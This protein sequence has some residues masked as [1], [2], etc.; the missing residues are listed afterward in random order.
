MQGYEYQPLVELVREQQQEQK[1]RNQATL[2][3]QDIREGGVLNTVWENVKTLGAKPVSQ[4]MAGAN[5]MNQNVGE[6]LSGTNKSLNTGGEDFEGV[7]LSN[8]VRQETADK[9]ARGMEKFTGKEDSLLER[10]AV[11]AYQTVMGLGDAIPALL[12]APITG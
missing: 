1:A 12:L 9:I 10:G 11:N 2:K 8:V 5:L 3:A 7:R 4:V 6:K